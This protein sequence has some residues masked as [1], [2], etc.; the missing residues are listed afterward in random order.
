MNSDYHKFIARRA[1]D[2]SLRNGN[3]SEIL[4]QLNLINVEQKCERRYITR[5]YRRVKK[6]PKR[7]V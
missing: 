6:L 4:C 7:R 3:A 5:P 2:V 1:T